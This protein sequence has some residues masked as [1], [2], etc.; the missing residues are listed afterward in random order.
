MSTT[1]KLDSGVL[2]CASMRGRIQVLEIN[3]VNSAKI[4][5]EVKSEFESDSGIMNMELSPYYNRSDVMGEYDEVEEEL[6]ACGT[7]IGKLIIFDTHNIK[8][9]LGNILDSQ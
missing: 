3:N 2:V 7:E 1:E 8:E 5:L 4:S 6:L 9:S